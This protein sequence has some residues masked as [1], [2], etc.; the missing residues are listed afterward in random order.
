LG[1]YHEALDDLKK[2]V[3]I[4]PT[5]GSNFY[6]I[7]PELVAESPDKAF[8]NRILALAD[9]TVK[10]HDGAFVRVGRSALLAAMGRDQEALTDLDKA[11]EFDSNRFEW[12][13]WRITFFADRARWGELH[14]EC[15]EAVRLKSDADDLDYVYY[16]LALAALGMSQ[17]QQYQAACQEMLEQFA[18]SEV[19]SETHFTAWT[20]ALAPDALD[21]Y[22]PTI[23]LARHAVEQ[24]EFNQQYLNGLGAILMRARR[25][26]EAKDQLQQALNVEDEESLTSTSYAYYFLAMTEHHLGNTEEAKEQLQIALESTEQELAGSPSWNRRLTLELLREEAV[27]LINDDTNVEAKELGTTLK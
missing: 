1:H 20:C 3:D 10:N 18:D 27:T 15:R 14:Q 17:D 9:K 23:E 19:P 5:D 7:P 21:D 4:N 11:V 2:A 8:R 13:T 26:D 12:R 6:W 16:K 24:E 22:E 25:Y